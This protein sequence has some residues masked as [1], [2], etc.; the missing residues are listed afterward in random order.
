[1]ILELLSRITARCRS[2]DVEREV[3]DELAFH[4]EMQTQSNI[5]S[6]MAPGEA[7]QTALRS[8]GGVEQTKEA[9]R[10]TRTIWLDS[11]VADLRYAS[12][13][14]L[15]APAFTLSALVTLG[16]G[17]GATTAVFSV[18]DAVALRPLPYQEPERL[19]SVHSRSVS[20]KRIST[21]VSSRDFLLWRDH[22][23]VF[24]GVAAVGGGSFRLIE[25]EPEELRGC[26]VTSGL[27][28]TLGAR[29]ILGD[30]F[31]TKHEVSGNHHVAVL[32]HGFW[33]RRFGGDPRIVGRRMRLDEGTY[34]VV[35][36]M[37][38]DFK[39]PAVGRPYD[40]WVAL[41]VDADARADASPYLGTVMRLK[42]GVTPEQAAA[43]L[44]ALSAWQGPA[45]GFAWRPFLVPYRE[46]E[47]GATRRWM[48]L[49][50]GAAAIVLLIACA[51]VAHL[52]LAQASG[53][54]RELAV[55]AALGGG[56]ARLVRQLA[57]ESLLL[58]SM[59]TL[60][61]LALAW[62]AVR[63][64]DAAAPASLRR[65]SQIA[66]D[67]RVLA[68]GVISGI[69]TGLSCGV[70]PALR[71]AKANVTAGLRDGGSPATAGPGGRRF[72]EALA[73]T[74]VA[75][76]FVLLAGACLFIVSFAR[77]MS[78][79]PGFDIHNVVTLQISVPQGVN[80][81]GRGLADT[82]TLVERLRQ[83]PGVTGAAV[84]AGGWMFGGGRH[85]YPAHKPGEPRP[86]GEA[87]MSDE[88]WVTPGLF[89]T[90]GIALL[91]GRDVSD[92]DTRAAPPVLLVNQTAARRHWPG[93]DPIGQHLVVV[94]RVYEVVGLVADIAHLGSDPA[95][96]PELYMPLAQKDG[97]VYGSFI[98]R[99]GIPP[100]G[101]MARIRQAVRS[102][103]PQQPITRLATLED[104][105]AR[106]TAARRFN[107]LLMSV[108]GVLALVIAISGLNGVMACTVAQRRREM[109]IR[110]TLGARRGQLVAGV[111]G[112]S[113]LIVLAGVVAGSCGAWA[114]G[115]FVQSYLFEVQ[116]HDPRILAAVGFFLAVTATAACWPPARRTSRADPVA[117]LKAE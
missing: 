9:V 76:S 101:A 19:F 86:A 114:L 91:R 105:I 6:G 61:G 66:I 45:A 24:D 117:A 14:L 29:P 92:L 74:E 35:G 58:S 13:L 54:Y 5:D 51:N 46:V 71:A 27:F 30:V 39:Y 109:A 75:L 64:L 72:R 4:L 113:A 98:L 107:M 60:A 23:Q 67:G 8:L 55:R 94:D 42:H 82:T 40:L 89:R 10:D 18:A 96:R 100:E 68:F 106:T 48:A 21:G 77:L 38:E 50:L 102:V 32:S 11:T 81:A 97:Q 12:R 43:H 44:E 2:R 115:R 69:V 99:T 33:Q 59:A 87:N 103:W 111:L 79:D 7:R 116:A 26:R 62:G 93:K 25:G 20:E 78:V 15:R 57:T 49:L 53:R 84:I 73:F 34:E 3:A 47:V 70:L 110:L 104:D 1:M 52:V 36:V 85:M 108:F 95:P 88:V 83:V 90:L 80:E 28:A 22:Q 17:I 56:P 63:L 41:P 16:V 37:P 112:R 31:D 65:I